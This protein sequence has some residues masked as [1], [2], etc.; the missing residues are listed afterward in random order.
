MS[1]DTN[2]GGIDV[3]KAESLEQEMAVYDALPPIVRKALQVCPLKYLAVEIADVIDEEGWSPQTTVAQIEHFAK[4]DVAHDAR[5]F[6]QQMKADMA[7][8]VRV[9]EERMP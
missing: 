9:I 8:I 7:R 3:H 1:D 2:T 6:E 4:M 5:I